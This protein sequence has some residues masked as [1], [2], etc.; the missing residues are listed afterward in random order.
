MRAGAM[1]ERLSLQSNTPTTNGYGE[2]VEAWTTQQTV[3]GQIENT[4]GGESEENQTLSANAQF[5]VTVRA[6]TNVTVAKRFQ[7]RGRN[8]SINFVQFD[9]KRKVTVCDCA[10]EVA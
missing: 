7:W 9:P 3:W 1:R 4:S 2:R 8:L 6:N 10:E 5:R